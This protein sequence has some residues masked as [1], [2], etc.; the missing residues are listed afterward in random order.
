MTQ[1]E[2]LFIVLSG[3]AVMMFLTAIVLVS[4]AT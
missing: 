4:G 3:I 1:K 2:L